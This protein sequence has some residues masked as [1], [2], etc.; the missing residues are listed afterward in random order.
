MT[1]TSFQLR[2]TVQAPLLTHAAGTL[3][4]GLDAATQRHRGQPVLNGSQLRGHLRHLL[5]R[6]ANLLEDAGSA[7][8]LSP[9]DVEL[10][11]GKA[12]GSDDNDHRGALS[13]DFYWYPEDTP[14]QGPAQPTRHRVELGDTGAAS[15]GQ[16]VVIEN[17]YPTGAQIVFRGRIRVRLGAVAFHE[18]PDADPAE[19]VS[20][21]RHWLAKAV[22]MLPAVGALKGVG[23]G[24]V[25]AAELVECRAV[26]RASVPTAEAVLAHDAT[27]LGLR[28]TLDRPFHFGAASAHRPND[29]RHVH[30]VRIPGAALKA[31]LANVW[32]ERGGNPQN[33]LHIDQ[34]VITDALPAPMRRPGRPAPL[35]LSLAVVA[36]GRGQPQVRDLAAQ[37]EPC[38]LDVGAGWRAPAF[39]PDWKRDDLRAAQRAWLG[40]EPEPVPA[41]LRVRTAI[42][43]ERRIADEARLFAIEYADVHSHVWCADID[44]SQVRDYERPRV[45]SHLADALRD[46][47]PGLGK[48]A[49]EAEALLLETPHKSASPKRASSGALTVLLATPARLLPDDLDVSGISGDADLARYYADYWE[50][51]SD[52]NLQLCHYFARQEMVGG[53]FYQLHFGGANGAADDYRPAWLTLTGSVFVLYPQATG[54]GRVQALLDEWQACGLPSVTG[55]DSTAY[56]TEPYLRENGYGEVYIDHPRHAELAPAP[57]EIRPIKRGA[58]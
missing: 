27:R 53:R 34:L 5:Q 51:A 48:S 32:R 42:D 58:A 11:F 56:K 14:R 55:A 45:H 3:S 29:N 24:R 2:L 26:L 17:A 36:D 7:D 47:L 50:R 6:Y 21:C 15:E 23:Y 33:D 30:G 52:G 37:P 12:E 44:L 1:S 31:V 18:F 19:V 39:L 25:V 10:W 4:L 40:I 38:L 13:F 35:P 20:R 57:P 43:P 22:Q 54:R 9:S 46:G 8:E 28:L 16:L 41:L 49:A